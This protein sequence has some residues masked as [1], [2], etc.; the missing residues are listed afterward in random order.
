MIKKMKRF[1]W[2]QK[3]AIADFAIT[4]AAASFTAGVITPF[5]TKV[6]SFAE[7]LSYLNGGIILSSISLGSALLILERKKL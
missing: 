1:S 3:K 6:Q 7:L 2:D 5:F 4:V